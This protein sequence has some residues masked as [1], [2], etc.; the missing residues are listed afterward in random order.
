MSSSLRALILL[1]LCLVPAPVLAQDT[2]PR[3]RRALPIAVTSVVGLAGATLGGGA[4]VVVGSQLT[5]DNEQASLVGPV[6]GLGIGAAL[7]T[8][9]SVWG[10]GWIVDRRQPGS[11][12]WTM[13][14]S[15][16]GGLLGMGL[17]AA[18][19]PTDE[20]IL[21]NVAGFFAPFFFIGGAVL[22]YEL[23][24]PDPVVSDTAPRTEQ[25]AI[26]AREATQSATGQDAL[27]APRLSGPARVSIES[28][29]GLVGFGLAFG[30]GRLL[31]RDRDFVPRLALTSG[32]ILAAPLVSS[33]AVFGAGAMIDD[34]ASR[35][36]L[37]WTALGGV[38]GFGAGL[39]SFGLLDWTGSA[40]LRAA[41]LALVPV[42]TT[43]GA[44]L[45]Y[46]R[47]RSDASP[48]GGRNVPLGAVT[49]QF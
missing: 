39:V 25:R 38:A 7:G 48:S 21:T 16:A 20:E 27:A 11:F 6:A 12:G 30:A 44:V 9:A 28:A 22:A 46:E 36:G 29:A 47:S 34:R 23:T 49:L 1:T 33:A 32:G 14:G 40:R 37:G 26:W 4:G 5:R 41:G 43:V 24:L 31:A 2:A 10:A 42:L 8:G 19:L 3:E 15:A 13:A 45:A 18:S 17:L 35:G